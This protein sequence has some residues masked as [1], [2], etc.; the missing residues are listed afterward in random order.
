[1]IGWL[2]SECD[3]AL[4]SVMVNMPRT[5][6][7]VLASQIMFLM[8]FQMDGGIELPVIFLLPF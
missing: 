2:K 1:M 6:G 4:I 7:F 3:I 5:N 8:L